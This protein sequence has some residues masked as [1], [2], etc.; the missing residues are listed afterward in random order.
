MR[1]RKRTTFRGGKDYY[2]PQGKRTDPSGGPVQT[3]GIYG[4]PTDPVRGLLLTP[5]FR[6]CS[7]DLDPD[8][9]LSQTS[10]FPVLSSRRTENLRERKRWSCRKLC[11]LKSLLK[12]GFGIE[13]WEGKI[14]RWVEGVF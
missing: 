5:T 2:L 12:R 3:T 9:W 8:Q 14:G 6:G 4:N 13:K 11:V 1:G 7:C 10:R